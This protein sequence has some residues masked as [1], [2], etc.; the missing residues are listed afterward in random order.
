MNTTVGF[1]FVLSRCRNSVCPVFRGDAVRLFSD[2]CNLYV[3]SFADC[4]LCVVCCRPHFP[5]LGGP[6]MILISFGNYGE[7]ISHRFAIK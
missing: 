1:S 5:S 3:L 2:F 7:Q 6:V 4:V